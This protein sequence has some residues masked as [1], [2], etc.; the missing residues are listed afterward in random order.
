MFKVCILF[1]VLSESVI[2]SAGL[3]SF[4]ENSVLP[5]STITEI[6]TFV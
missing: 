6:G 4:D 1:G 2:F 5:V 3:Y